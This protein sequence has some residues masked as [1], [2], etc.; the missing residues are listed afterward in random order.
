M[1]S[2]EITVAELEGRLA[3]TSA[4]D[5]RVQFCEQASNAVDSCGRVLWAFGCAVDMPDRVGSSLLAEHT[6]SPLGKNRYLWCDLGQQLERYGDSFVLAV[7]AL[8]LGHIWIIQGARDQFPRWRAKWKELDSLS[9]WV[10][11]KAED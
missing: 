11:I 4:H 1:S 10:S 7:D 6:T 8:D 9:S 2:E 3:D 5:A